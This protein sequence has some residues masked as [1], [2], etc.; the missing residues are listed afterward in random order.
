MPKH[1]NTPAY[2]DER[3]A[4]YIWKT[5][6]ALQ[7]DPFTLLRLSSEPPNLDP[8][9]DMFEDSID[10]LRIVLKA[11]APTTIERH[12]LTTWI[13]RFMTEASITMEYNP[14]DPG[15]RFID[16]PDRS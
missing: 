16:H 3:P 11:V 14:S 10:Y 8:H 15:A 7:I 6:R 13:R 5:A 9:S 12:W 1:A 4:I 2:Q